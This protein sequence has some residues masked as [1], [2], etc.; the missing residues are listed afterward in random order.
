METDFKSCALFTRLAGTRRIASMKRQFVRDV[1]GPGYHR[2]FH[3]TSYPVMSGNTITACVLF[4]D[5]GPKA[6][7]CHAVSISMASPFPEN[8]DSRPEANGNA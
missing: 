8:N 4:A 2:Q 5:S 1:H 6:E 3:G 7:T